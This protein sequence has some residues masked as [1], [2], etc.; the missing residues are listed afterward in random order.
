VT[1]HP[2]LDYMPVVHKYPCRYNVHAY[3][4]KDKS[5]NKIKNKD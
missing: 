1:H 3:K 2:A 5:K 4:N